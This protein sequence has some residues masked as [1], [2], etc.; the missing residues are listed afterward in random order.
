MELD[1]DKAQ[2]KEWEDGALI[3]NVMP[4]L[5]VIEREFLITGM[6]KK[7]QKDLFCLCYEDWYDS[8]ED[9]I[10]IELAESGADRELDFNSEDEFEVRYAKYLKTFE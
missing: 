2:I 9:D 3:Q 4:Q 6:N 7:E 10:N 1:V 5:S 8:N